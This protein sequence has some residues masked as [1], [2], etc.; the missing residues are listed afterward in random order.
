LAGAILVTV[1]IY[2]IIT[3]WNQGYLRLLSLPICA[4]IILIIFIDINPYLY[5]IDT[6]SYTEI[7]TEIEVLPSQ[8]EVFENGRI[9]WSWMPGSESNYFSMLNNLSITSGWNPEGSSHFRTLLLHNIAIP[10]GYS[11]YV[12]KNLLQW[13]TRYVFLDHAHS[14]LTESLISNGFELIKDD[15]TKAVLFNSIPSSYFMRQE[16]NAIAIGRASPG[17]IMTFPWLVQG[18]SSYLEDYSEKYLSRFSLIYLVEPEVRSFNKFEEI[19]GKLAGEGKTVIVEMGRAENWP[20]LGIVPYWET[21]VSGAEILPINDSPF[22][23]RFILDADPKGRAS[24][25]GNLDEVWMEVKMGEKHLPALGYKYSGGNRVYFLGLAL[26][27]QLESSLKWSRGV[28]AK[29]S[30]GDDIKDLLEQL[31]D[32]AEPHKSIVPAAFPVKESE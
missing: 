25:L 15:K 32:L 5:K 6:K 28:N 19:L 14:E 18:Y 7:Q 10:G 2:R 26:S 21:I 29:S 4:A 30:S 31:M 9:F 13:N 1:F 11:D 17:L 12:V 24:A 3:R 20:V 27:Q 16:R 8:K 22:E 23:Q